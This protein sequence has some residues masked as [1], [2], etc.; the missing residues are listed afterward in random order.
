MSKSACENLWR[1]CTI[2]FGRF[3]A[4][5]C[6]E[7]GLKELSWAEPGRRVGHKKL[8]TGEEEEEDVGGEPAA[9]TGVGWLRERFSVGIG[10]R[11]LGADV[12]RKGEET[13]PWIRVQTVSCVQSEQE[14]GSGWERRCSDTLRDA[15]HFLADV[16]NALYDENTP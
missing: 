1:G 10:T 16:R 13:S 12:R 11:G 7:R 5:K 6:A 15:L 2:P 8:G 9:E 14:C 4:Q 3:F